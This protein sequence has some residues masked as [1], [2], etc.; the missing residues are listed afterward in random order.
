MLVRAVGTDVSSSSEISG[1]LL[2]TLSPSC[3]RLIL[4]S[5]EKTPL[6]TLSLE[7]SMVF[8]DADICR[9]EASSSETLPPRAA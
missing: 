6:R 8:G 7:R 9:T 2:V 5:T 3:R 4:S 1:K